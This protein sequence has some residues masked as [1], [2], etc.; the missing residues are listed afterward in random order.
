MLRIL[1]TLNQSQGGIY[2]SLR[3]LSGIKEHGSS[4]T[5]RVAGV[6]LGLQH[7]GAAALDLVCAGRE[8][9]EEGIDVRADLVRRAAAGVGGDLRAH[10]VPEVLGG[11]EVG[12]VGRQVDQAQVQVRRGEV[13]TEFDVRTGQSWVDPQRLRV[14]QYEVTVER[15]AA[16]SDG[17]QAPVPG[18]VPGPYVA[19]TYATSVEREYVVVEIPCPVR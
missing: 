1:E 11:V 16:Q 9:D 3:R 14:R 4:G 13:V 2:I 12:A 19:E 5:H 8:P 6:G 18:S 10:P 7:G 17:L 15:A